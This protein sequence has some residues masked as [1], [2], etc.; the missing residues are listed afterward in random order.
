M[1]TS[2]TY[3]YSGKL[4][5]N[6]YPYIYKYHFLSRIVQRV[7]IIITYIRIIPVKM[8]VA[9]SLERAKEK[10]LRHKHQERSQ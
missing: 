7:N 9:N 6:I 8:I 4:I 5:Y 10:S 3:I 1:H 2:I